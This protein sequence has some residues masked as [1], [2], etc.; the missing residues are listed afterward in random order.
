MADRYR[1]PT[2]ERLSG[3][4]R[5]HFI[6]YDGDV[7]ERLHATTIASR[8][9]SPGR[10]IRITTW[11]TLSHCAI[12][13][14]PSSTS[15][16]TTCCSHAA[17]AHQSRRRRSGSRSTFAISAGC[18]RVAIASCSTFPIPPRNCWPL[19]RGRL[20]DDLTARTGTKPQHLRIEVDECFGN[21]A[22]CDLDS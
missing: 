12:R 9:K 8:P 22:V 11:S 6:T 7:C 15:S 2:L 10:S 3:L 17:P 20:S 19:Y 16:T 21:V 13:S 14:R 1:R 18:S 4:Q 5:R